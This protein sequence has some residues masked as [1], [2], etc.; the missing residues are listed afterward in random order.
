[1]AIQTYNIGS[2]Q[3][4][5]FYNYNYDHGGASDQRPGGAPVQ[6]R[7]PSG[8]GDK[9]NESDTRILK[10]PSVSLASLGGYRNLSGKIDALTNSVNAVNG[11]VNSV[12]N[13][14]DDVQSGVTNISG[15]FANVDRNI[16][17]INK[18]VDTLRSQSSQTQKD[19]ADIETS[20]GRIGPKVDQI[21][22]TVDDINKNCNACGS[23]P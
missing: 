13:K 21:Q 16:G 4:V 8:A 15:R 23:N 22:A 5:Q 3:Q 14:L 19:L 2:N 7:T 20:L 17:Q 12:S 1:M 10:N 18:N 9:G 11:N 6:S